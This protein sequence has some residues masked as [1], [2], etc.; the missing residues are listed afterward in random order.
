M[1]QLLP[2][3]DFLSKLRKYPELQVQ[4]DDPGVFTQLWSQPP[5]LLSHSSMSKKVLKK[6][7]AVNWGISGSLPASRFT[8][9][10]HMK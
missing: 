2:S 7:A 6:E 5:L 8:I 10:L 1:R 3:Q 4:T 9:P